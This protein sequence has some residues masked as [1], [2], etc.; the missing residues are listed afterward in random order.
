MHLLILFLIPREFEKLYLFT[1]KW[2]C[3][4]SSELS[5][6]YIYF[7]TYI[8][9]YNMCVVFLFVFVFIDSFPS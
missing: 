6:T 3:V 8:N 7:I 2:F 4:F 5:D 9:L 1:L